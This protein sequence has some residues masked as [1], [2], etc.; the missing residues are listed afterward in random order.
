MK[1][2]TK[3]RKGPS[4]RWFLIKEFCCLLAQILQSLFLYL[5]FSLLEFILKNKIRNREWNQKGTC[6]SRLMPQ[7]LYKQRSPED[8]WLASSPSPFPGILPQLIL[9]KNFP[10]WHVVSMLA[11][12]SPVASQ[13]CFLLIYWLPH[14]SAEPSNSF[15]FGFSL[16]QIIHILKD[17]NK[18]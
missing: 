8:I 10:P 17:W 12:L 1:S 7:T 5:F 16:W 11:S 4:V 13:D 2:E 3:E 18:V 14:L 9:L 15:S 6:L